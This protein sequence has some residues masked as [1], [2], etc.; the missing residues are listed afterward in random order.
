MFLTSKFGGEG[1][2]IRFELHVFRFYL[3][4]LRYLQYCRP[5]WGTCW[6]WIKVHSTSFSLCL[7]VPSNHCG[8]TAATSP[9]PALRL[10]RQPTPQPCS[11]LS[12]LVS[13]EL[14]LFTTHSARHARKTAQRHSSTEHSARHLINKVTQILSTQG[15][16]IW[17]PGTWQLKTIQGVIPHTLSDAMGW[18][19]GVGGGCVLIV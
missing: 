11:G 18:V 1:L 8:I 10:T 3:S 5:T 15:H 14:P 6:N 17:C 4:C 12:K 13:G 16:T 9:T 2:Q 7:E 19:A